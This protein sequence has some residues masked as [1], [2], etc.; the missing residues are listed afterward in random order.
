MASTNHWNSLVMWRIG[1]KWSRM[2]CEKSPQ[3]SNMSTRT[4]VS[5]VWAWKADSTIF[6]FT[7][8][9]IKFYIQTCFHFPVVINQL[10]N[11][12][13]F[14]FRMWTSK[15]TVIIWWFDIWFPKSFFSQ[16]F[17]QSSNQCTMNHRGWK[18]E[19]ICSLDKM[20]SVRCTVSILVWNR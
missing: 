12:C 19:Q 17:S 1:P 9:L 5:Q 11:Y 4:L 7:V 2:I 8:F 14:S 13:S 18:C 10:L 3:Y 6:L 16:R 20:Q 15:W